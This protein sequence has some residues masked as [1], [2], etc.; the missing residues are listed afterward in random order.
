MPEVIKV[1]EKCYYATSEY[2]SSLWGKYAWL[3]Q[4]QGSLELTTD[5]LTY[6]SKRLSFTIPLASIIRIHVELFSRWAKPFGLMYIAVEY[7]HDGN[8]R[9]I[10]LVPAKSAF[11][12]TW[13]TANIIEDWLTTF[14][15]IAALSGV[16]KLA[17]PKITRPTIAQLVLYFAGFVAVIAA[18][19]FVMTQLLWLAFR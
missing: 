3:Y 5:A 18:V 17:I 12:P 4:G 13:K 6:E 1:Q 10:I 14:S 7:L 16:V 15:Q 2:A 8:T 9:A 11:T 19:I